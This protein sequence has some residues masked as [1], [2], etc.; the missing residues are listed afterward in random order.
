MCYA[1][2][3]IE[4]T[5]TDLLLLRATRT[6]RS[7]G[8]Y[9][10]R[11]RLPDIPHLNLSSLSLSLTHTPSPPTQRKTTRQGPF[12]SAPQWQLL[13]EKRSHSAHQH[14]RHRVVLL[15]FATPSRNPRS[16]DFHLPPDQKFPETTSPT[17]NGAAPLY[18]RSACSARPPRPCKTLQTLDQTFS[19]IPAPSLNRKPRENF[20]SARA[21]SLTP[22]HNT[23]AQAPERCVL[24]QHQIDEQCTSPRG[25]HTP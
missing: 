17:L 14:E 15:A 25:R 23:A 13:L 20:R 18:R 11:R 12:E 21:G 1:L 16:D 10:H 2:S 19:T 3:H 7:R 9:I 4:L 8:P 6:S 5:H 24:T 22:M